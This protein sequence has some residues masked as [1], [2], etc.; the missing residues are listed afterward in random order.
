MGV[1]HSLIPL[2]RCPREVR[3]SVRGD[4]GDAGPTPF[5]LLLGAHEPQTAAE[6]AVQVEHVARDLRR[7]FADGLRCNFAVPPGGLSALRLRERCVVA[8]PLCCLWSFARGAR[9]AVV[10]HARCTRARRPHVR[11]REHAVARQTRAHVDVVV[12]SRAE[13]SCRCRQRGMWQQTLRAPRVGL[14]CLHCAAAR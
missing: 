10:T 1:A 4:G 5:R 13:S 11:L 6:R 12:A 8:P 14:I 3:S 9:R 7:G 2:S